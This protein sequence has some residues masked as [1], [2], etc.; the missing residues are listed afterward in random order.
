ML[1]YSCIEDTLIFIGKFHSSIPLWRTSPSKQVASKPL[2][3]CSLVQSLHVYDFFCYWKWNEVAF[4]AR[5]IAYC[6][7]SV[8]RHSKL[9]AHTWHNQLK[10]DSQNL[11]PADWMDN[12]QTDYAP[13]HTK[14]MTMQKRRCCPARR[15]PFCPKVKWPHLSVVLLLL[16]SV[17]RSG[18]ILVWCKD[19]PPPCYAN[20]QEEHCRPEKIPTNLQVY[21]ARLKGGPLVAKP[22]RSSKQEQGQN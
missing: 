18:H 16:V 6:V 14:K 5:Y 1:H 17:L 13:P 22:R 7:R 15:L 10:R 9:S 11:F 21:T 3:R 8:E 2:R 19:R 12:P 20:R 4:F